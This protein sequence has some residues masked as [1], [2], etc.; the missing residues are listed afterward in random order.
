MDIFKRAKKVLKK[1]GHVVININDVWSADRRIPLHSRV[2]DSMQEIGYIFNDTIIWDKR[3]TINNI[4]IIG[5]PSRYVSIGVTFEY[6][7]HFVLN[8]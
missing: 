6:L 2:I 8:D 3:Q 1:N 5:W 4:G 7:L